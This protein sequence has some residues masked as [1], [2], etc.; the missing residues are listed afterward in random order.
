MLGSHLSFSLSVCV[1]VCVV[2]VLCVCVF[3][4]STQAVRVGGW[5]GFILV[6]KKCIPVPNDAIIIIFSQN[7]VISS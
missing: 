6:I 2:C 7:L 3:P 5:H 1:C 4:N